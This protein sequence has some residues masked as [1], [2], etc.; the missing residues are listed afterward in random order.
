[1][2]NV[3][4]SNLSRETIIT[5]FTE[6]IPDLTFEEKVRVVSAIEKSVPNWNQTIVDEYSKLLKGQVHLPCVLN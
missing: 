3:K 5:E 6:L 4:P 2:K 1:M